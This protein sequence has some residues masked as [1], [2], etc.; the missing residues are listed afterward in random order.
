MINVFNEDMH[1][2]VKKSNCAHFASNVT[3]SKTKTYQK[4]IKKLAIVI[5]ILNENVY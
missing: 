2:I 3:L 5:S 1:V 4:K